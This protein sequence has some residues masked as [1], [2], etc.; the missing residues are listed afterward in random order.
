MKRYIVTGGLGHIGSHV[1]DELVSRGDR[2]LI[3]DNV[4][5]GKLENKNPQA[6]LLTCSVYDAP[7]DKIIS[8]RDWDCVIHLAAFSNVRLGSDEPIR[9]AR[10]GANLTVAMLTMCKAQKIPKMIFVSSAVVEYNPHIPYG[11]EKEAG[12]RYCRYFEKQFGLNVSIIR[13]HNLY[14]SPRH[15][16][17]TGNVIPA[18]IEQKKQNGKIQITGDGSQV[19]DFVYY[20]DVVAAILEAENR[21]GLTEIGTCQGHSILEVAKYFNCPI[22]FIGKPAGEVDWQVCKK[23]DYEAKISLKQGMK[24]MGLN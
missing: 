23:S 8:S 4:L 12:E 24:L 10:D 9:A 6:E 19:R 11:I 5:T 21:K 2:V 3:V 15:N 20:T 7:H 18:F 16:P 22:E 13:L 1:V 17:I 14:G